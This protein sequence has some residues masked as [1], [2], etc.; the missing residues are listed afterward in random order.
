MIKEISFETIQE[1]WY[2]EDMWGQLAY[3]SPV[4]TMMYLEGYENRIRDLSYSCPV[5]YAYMSD[6]QI[7]GVNSYHRVNDE[8][9]RS[10]G[11]YVFPKYRK[12]SIGVELLKYAIDQNRKL[13]YEFIWSMPR[14]TAIKVY[15]NARFQMTTE[16][17][18][19]LPDGQKV[20]YQNCFCKYSYIQPQS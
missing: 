20:L 7:A 11:L 19:H 17:F 8:Q 6:N 13:G 2:A 12:L 10:R 1:I 15:K 14:S 5:F 18:S 4:S 16:V 3:A 9:C